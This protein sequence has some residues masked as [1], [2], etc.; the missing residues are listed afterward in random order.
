MRTEQPKEN[1]TYIYQYVILYLPVVIFLKVQ[2]G[3]DWRDG[4]V[5]RALVAL[6]DYQ[7][8]VPCIYMVG[9]NHP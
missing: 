4:S 2:G 1:I 6:A 5:V 7:G 3:R 8:S 9:Y